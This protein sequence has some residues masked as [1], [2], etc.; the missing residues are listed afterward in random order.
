VTGFTLGGKIWY[1]DPLNVDYNQDGVGDQREWNKDTDHDNNPDL[2][3]FDNDN[4]GVPDKPDM[5]PF[6]Q[7]PIAMTTYIPCRDFQ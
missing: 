7:G 5:S 4:D 2:W 3:S 1:G 6:E